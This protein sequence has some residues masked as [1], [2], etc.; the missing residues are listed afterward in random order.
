MSRVRIYPTAGDLADAVA[1]EFARAVEQHV[2]R[3]IPLFVALSGGTT[4][5]ILFRRLAQS[6][7][8]ESIS[9]R[10]VHF[11]WG[12]ERCVPPEHPESNFGQA[13][14]LLLSH[15]PIPRE[16]IHRIR[17]EAPAEPEAERYAEEIRRWV[18]VDETE[19]PRFDWIFLG[20]GED[21]HIASL[22]PG[23]PVLE[24]RKRLCAVATHP[25]TGQQRIT[26]TFPVINNARRILF[27]VTGAK[28]SGVV[29]EILKGEPTA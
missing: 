20:V 13:D 12:D 7:W 16:N 23:S 24:E 8:Q 19:V 25:H 17:G 29:R 27:L 3:G 21:G 10:R 15:I 9:W 18:P 2:H 11:F 14:T 22:F 6:P 4:P 28:K 5:A 1:Q 26:V